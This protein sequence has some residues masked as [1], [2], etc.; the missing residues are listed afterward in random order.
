MQITPPSVLKETSAPVPVSQLGFKRLVP[1][2]GQQLTLLSLE[3]HAATRY[4]AGQTCLQ[5]A[6]V[7]ESLLG[8][9]CLVPGKGSSS[10][11]SAWRCTLPPGQC[12]NQ[13]ADARHSHWQSGAYRTA[14]S[15]PCQNPAHDTLQRARLVACL[16]RST[17]TQHPA[18]SKGLSGATALQA[19]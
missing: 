15:M 10:P 13:L 12:P 17:L 2:K 3:V 9:K 16:Q 7:T 4:A 8:F 1:G 14:V 5:K 19:P 6:R 18:A 11:C